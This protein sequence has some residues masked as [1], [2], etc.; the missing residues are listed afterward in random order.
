VAFSYSGRHPITD[1]Q[2]K[3]S[4][5]V[6]SELK[7]QGIRVELDDRSESIGRKIRDAQ[8]QKV[9]YML[10]VGE[11]EEKAKQI[12]VRTRSQKDLGAMKL[13]KFLDKI[14]KEIETKSLS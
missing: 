8:M 6:F 4:E 9:P 3:Y 2:N 5:K 10:V 12:A 1:K 7:E 11:K 14:K 13:G